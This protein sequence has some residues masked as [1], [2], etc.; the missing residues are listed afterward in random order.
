M[1]SLRE[2]GSRSPAGSAGERPPKDVR[3][4]ALRRFAIS[5]TVLNILGYA[6]LGFEQPW[7][8]PLI[9]VG[10]A[11]AT[12]ILTETITAWAER[13]PPGYA[14]RGMKGLVDYLLPAHITGLA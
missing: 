9:A 10:V 8:W 12:E 4:T 6:W 13:R 7:L 3:I 2:E 5:I 11:Y 1:T 14:G